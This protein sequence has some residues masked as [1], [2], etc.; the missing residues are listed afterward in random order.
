MFERV[1]F[2]VSCQ[3]ICDFSLPECSLFAKKCNR[4]FSVR[5]VH[6]SVGLSVCQHFQRCSLEIHLVKQT[7]LI[8]SL[9]TNFM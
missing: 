2:F 1:C 3:D 8:K 9:P 5:L 7:K 4:S 6:P